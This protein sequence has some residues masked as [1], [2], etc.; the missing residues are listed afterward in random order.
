MLSATQGQM[1]MTRVESKY[2]SLSPSTAW[3][4]IV[5]GEVSFGCSL[6]ALDGLVTAQRSPLTEEMSFYWK[7]IQRRRKLLTKRKCTVIVY[8]H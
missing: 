2:W 8:D 6:V 5:S 7:E 4:E 1:P 3:W